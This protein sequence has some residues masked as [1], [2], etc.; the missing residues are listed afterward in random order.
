[1]PKRVEMF[2]IVAFMGAVLTHS[3]PLRADEVTVSG[4]TAYVTRHDCAALVGHLPPPSID[5]K[6]GVDVHG[7][8]VAP[9]DLPAG[10]PDLGLP[11]RITFE[12]KVNPLTYGGAASTAQSSPNR[13]AETQTS[14]GKVDVDPNTGAVT[15]NGQPLGGDDNRAVAEACRKA[16]FR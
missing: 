4:A 6:P 11:D 12:L 15:I 16:G 8:Y 3:L 9:A 10:T 13:F 7:K 2:L 14:M 1:M 5:Y